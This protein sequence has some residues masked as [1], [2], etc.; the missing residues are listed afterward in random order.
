MAPELDVAGLPVARDRRGIPLM[1]FE[2]HHHAAAIERGR[3]RG[4]E[5][6]RPD[7]ASG[8]VR[9]HRNRIEAGDRALRS[10]Q[11]QRVAGEPAVMLDHDGFGVG[12][13]RETAEN[14]AARCDRWQMP[15]FRVRSAGQGRRVARGGRAVP[16][17]GD[18]RARSAWPNM[19]FPAGTRKKE[20]EPFPALQRPMGEET[21]N[22]CDRRTPPS[23]PHASIQS[24][25]PDRP[26]PG[27]SLFLT[28]NS[29]RTTDDR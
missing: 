2:P 10:E 11:D 22:H 25:R 8:A 13:S 6:R 1:H 9:G 3:F 14:P 29:G 17:P 18:G 19:S 5:Q 16:K 27:G 28:D 23:A 7:P 20:G 15:D 24:T 4:S 12:R 21:N 26:P